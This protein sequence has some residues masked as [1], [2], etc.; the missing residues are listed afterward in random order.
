MLLGASLASP[1]AHADLGC[2]GHGGVSAG[3]AWGRRSRFPGD[4][5]EEAEGWAVLG[6]SRPRVFSPDSPGRSE[7]R[8][9][10]PPR[11][12]GLALRGDPGDL[13]G[14]VVPPGHDF[15][16]HPA[17][18]PPPPPLSCPP[19]EPGPLRIARS[20]AFWAVPLGSLSAALSPL[21]HVLGSGPG[22]GSLW[23]AEPMVTAAQG[24]LPDQRPKCRTGLALPGDTGWVL[25]DVPV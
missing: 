25:S 5:G 17:E 10:E 6:V 18:G 12:C 13:L 15:C 7:R 1:A 9:F 2:G 3:P 11:P 20:G 19:S 22:T 8:C 14:D 24:C 23:G 4:P 21:P 16:K